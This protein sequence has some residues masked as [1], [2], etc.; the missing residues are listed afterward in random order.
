[1]AKRNQDFQTI[2]SQGALLPP[3]ILRRISAGAIDGTKASDFGL[4]SCI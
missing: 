1:M 4:P 3:D 2:T